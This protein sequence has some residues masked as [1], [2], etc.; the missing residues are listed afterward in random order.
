[1]KTVSLADV[2]RSL[3]VTAAV[4]C[5]MLIFKDSLSFADLLLAVPLALIA[6]KKPSASL[7]LGL[8][9]VFP[10]ISSSMQYF[11]AIYAIMLLFLLPQ[12]MYWR[13]MT[14]LLI[15]LFLTLRSNV[16]M[17]GLALVLSSFIILDPLQVARLSIFY[18]TISTLI[19]LVEPSTNTVKPLGMLL[20]PCET[21]IA[22]S[23]TQNP[24]KDAIHI[25]TSYVQALTSHDMVLLYQVLTL[26]LAATA[27]SLT[28]AGR[29]KKDLATS[30]LIPLTA[31][32]AS[33]TV[34]CLKLLGKT[35]I[36]ETYL[37]F[38]AL[39]FSLVVIMES[40]AKLWKSSVPAPKA[41]PKTSIHIVLADN[42]ASLHAIASKLHLKKAAV[43]DLS[44]KRKLPRIGRR[45][46]LSKLVLAP[47]SENID[48][49]LKAI[50]A[51]GA[52]AE[53]IY[54]VLKN[55]KTAAEISQRLKVKTV[56][57]LR[58]HKYWK[59]IIGLSSL[60]TELVKSIIIPAKL[61]SDS[62]KPKNILLVGP[63][64]SGKTLLVDAIYEKLGPLGIKYYSLNLPDKNKT[65]KTLASLG[66]KVVLIDDLDL[67]F[68]NKEKSAELS[69]LLKDLAKKYS[70]VAT[71]YDLQAIPPAALS[72]FDHI[73]K[74]PPPTLEDI[75]LFLSKHSFFKT[76]NIDPKA[77]A[78]KFQGLY[79]GK[80]I[81]VLEE[82][83]R[84]SIYRKIH[85]G[86]P[87]TLEELEKIASKYSHQRILPTQALQLDNIEPRIITDLR[88]K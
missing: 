16:P 77:A 82:A 53:E 4:L 76:L 22:A 9:L 88:K 30:S 81:K 13:S 72:V 79:F 36:L 28:Y 43:V 42:S 65:L 60:K 85:G 33:Y 62:V 27:A 58:D 68:Y 18:S 83:K 64:G 37:L 57:D 24:L 10:E 66:A 7:A 32:S 25:V 47:P 80:I 8:L 50:N 39:Y 17:L 15:A 44:E 48:S 52:K 14:I 34:S 21:N 38:A 35:P 56:V 67:A 70:I 19:A 74:I 49:V 29:G 75:E 55:E 84:T 11:L 2:A 3:A 1:M 54:L 46:H 59:Q 86:P 23:L 31:I 71:A 6:L 87:L 40:T 5:F 45:K 63:P 26:P 41:L 20:V 78:K 51:L 69:S 73:V 12:S 61:K